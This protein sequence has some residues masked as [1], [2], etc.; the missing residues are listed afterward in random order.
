MTSESG[1]SYMMVQ[2]SVIVAFNLESNVC[3][4]QNTDHQYIIE[5]EKLKNIRKVLRHNKQN[6]D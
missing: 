1:V 6:R 2:I 5:S 4:I 3:A